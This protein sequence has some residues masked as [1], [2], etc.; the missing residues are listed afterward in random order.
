MAESGRVSA[1]KPNKL[2]AKADAGFSLSEGSRFKNVGE[3]AAKREVKF[4]LFAELQVQ[5]TSEP[6]LLSK[7]WRFSML[8]GHGR[9]LRG[10]VRSGPRAEWSCYAV[11]PLTHLPQ[12]YTIANEM[13]V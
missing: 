13:A 12:L 3:S 10:L 6:G 11:V 4:L 2:P 9:W 1:T 7:V 5:S 8:M